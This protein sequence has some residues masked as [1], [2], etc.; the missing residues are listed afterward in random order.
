MTNSINGYVTAIFTAPGAGLPVVRQQRVV[1][2]PGIGLDGDR[3]A[4]GTGYWSANLQVSRNLTL[5]ES[6]VIESLAAD[7]GVA[8]EPGALRRNVVTSG[9][10]LNDLVGVRFWIGDVEVLG[11]RLCEPCDHLATA[12]GLPIVAPLVHRGGLRADV[13]TAGELVEGARIGHART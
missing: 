11:T 13:L 9:V 12:L 4:A 5:I 6:E 3:Y 7:L 1:A 10:R 2:R 8:L